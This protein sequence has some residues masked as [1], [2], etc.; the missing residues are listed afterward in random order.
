MILR[1]I[2]KKALEQL[3]IKFPELREQVLILEIQELLCKVLDCVREKLITDSQKELSQ[4]QIESLP[5]L[6]N[7]I[8]LLN[9]TH[10]GLSPFLY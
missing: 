9:L 8:L 4:N 3:K 7:R 10:K 2:Q 1:N 5:Y 6:L